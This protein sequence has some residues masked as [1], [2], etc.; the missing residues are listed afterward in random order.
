M[1]DEQPQPELRWAPLPPKPRRAGRVWLII[2]LVV[3]A[4][5]VVAVVLFFLI[6]RGDGVAPTAS[7]SPSASASPSPSPSAAPSETAVPE[8]PTE[9]TEPEPTQTP[10]TSQPPVSDPSVATFRGQVSGWLDDALTGIDIV[11]GTSG[12]EA[13]DVVDS[14]QND[15]QRLGE[16]LPPSSIESD[17]NAAVGTYS[18]ALSTLRSAASSGSGLSGA[19]D[20]ARSAANELRSIVGL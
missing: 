18:Q 11:S 5:V 16:S 19:L 9:T 3:A 14:L 7:P 4:I 10:I 8:E 15:A 17:W 13:V 12:Q 20:G 1:S 6:P 2:G